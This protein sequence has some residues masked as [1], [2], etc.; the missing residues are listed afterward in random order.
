MTGGNADAIIQSGEMKPSVLNRGEGKGKWIMRALI[1]GDVRGSVYEWVP[2]EKQKDV[3]KN[4]H[5]TDDTVL[6]IA[7]ADAL[8]E[9]RDRGIRDDAGIVAMVT[10]KLQLYGRRYPDAGYSRSFRAWTESSDPKPYGSKTNGAIMRCAAAGWLADSPEE[11]RRLGRLTAMPTHD[12]PEALDAAGL[13]AEVIYRLRMGESVERMYVLVSQF[14]TIPRLKDIRPI[15]E[16][17]FTCKTTLPIAFAAFYEAYLK[18]MDLSGYRDGFDVVEHAVDYA[19]SLGGD[20]DTNAA[21]AAAFAEAH[22]FACSVG[23]E[24]DSRGSRTPWYVPE[25]SYRYS[26]EQTAQYCTPDILSVVER[27]DAAIAEISPLRR[28]GEFLYRTDKRGEAVIVRYMGNTEGENSVQLEIPDCLDGFPVTAIGPDAFEYSL[29]GV[30]KRALIILPAGVRSIGDRAFSCNADV[31]LPDGVEVIGAYAFAYSGGGIAQLP[32]GLKILGAYAFFGVMVFPDLREGLEHMGDMACYSRRWP[33]GWRNEKCV[34]PKSL[35]RIGD[36]A[37]C[38]NADEFWVYRDSAGELYCINQDIQYYYAEPETADAER[39]R[40]KNDRNERQMRME[41][42]AEEYRRRMQAEAELYE[43][44]EVNV[45]RYAGWR[46]HYSGPGYYVD[47][48]ER[49]YKIVPKKH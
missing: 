26:W 11:A 5:F 14:Y 20:T 44:E 9:C 1:Y 34:I 18:V 49:V 7:V 22:D 37:I 32:V 47:Q 3:E 6:G 41:T 33:R 38:P 40:L 31:I 19:I 2:V 27:M 17:D 28:C 21:I 42:Q 45:Q 15:T 10:Q 4:F 23:E 48:D 12:H 30:G 13:A 8:L 46:E 35:K 43:Y 16:F 36:L 24:Y 25:F 39:E 29:F